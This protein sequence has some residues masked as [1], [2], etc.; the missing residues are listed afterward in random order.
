[1][2]HYK[3]YAGL[4][5]GLMALLAA[6]G[7]SAKKKEVKATTPV[8]KREVC[9]TVRSIARPQSVQVVKVTDGTTVK[10][11]VIVRG[12]GTDTTRVYRYT[13]TMD[14]GPG[15][16]P[17]MEMLVSLA[18]VGKI[19]AEVKDTVMS[20]KDVKRWRFKSGMNSGVLWGAIM[21][22]EANAYWNSANRFAVEDLIGGCFYTPS[23]NT[24][25]GAGIGFGVDIY[26]IHSSMVPV[27]DRFNNLSFVE[28]PKQNQKQRTRLNNGFVDFN[29]SLA[30][31]FSRNFY[32]S[33][34]A[35]LLYN[36]YTSV[37]CHYFTGNVETY[38]YT[39]G[40][41]QNPF[42]LELRGHMVFGNNIGIYG[43]WSP[44]TL[45]NGVR[46]PK[47]KTFVLGV[48]LVSF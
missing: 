31:R 47:F 23:G 20:S 32:L 21:S 17:E 18:G 1:M 5:L 19:H 40:L 24:R 38:N 22:T 37:R 44:Q 41:N 14:A 30:Q 12:E 42:Q 48:E 4:T 6:P 34:S 3:L 35:A 36:A 29:V 16:E 25:F 15:E 11:Q 13:Y 43:A 28:A 10:H 26:N 27:Q 39:S 45:F 9:D 33:A 2:I 8:A 46:G 7:V